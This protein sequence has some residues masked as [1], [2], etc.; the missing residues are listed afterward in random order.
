MG[1]DVISPSRHIECN[2]AHSTVQFI[3]KVQDVS[4]LPVG[5]KMCFGRED[6]FREL[7]QT[8][9][10]ESVFPDYISI[11]GAEGGTGASPKSFMDDFGTP[12][13]KALPLVHSIL[14]EEGVRDRL[15]LLCAGKLVNPGRQLLALSM[16]A[17]ACYTARGFMLAIGCVQALQCNRNTCP[18]GITT[19]NPLLKSGLDIET[20][21]ERVK[22]YVLNLEHEYYEMLSALGVSSFRDLNASHVLAPVH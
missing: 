15:K 20:K 13:F 16:G 18:V 2:D 19:H 10:S 22:N 6:E 3:K 11:D 1:K 12:L 5:I 21:S 4:K 14:Q 9:K 7:V 8:M 17:D